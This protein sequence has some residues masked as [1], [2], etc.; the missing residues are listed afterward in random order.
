MLYCAGVDTHAF[1]NATLSNQPVTQF[2]LSSFPGKSA[3]KIQLNLF[4]ASVSK[5]E[6]S[7]ELF[8]GSNQSNRTVSLKSETEKYHVMI[9]FHT[10]VFPHEDFQSQ[11]TH[12]WVKPVA[13]PTS[14]LSGLGGAPTQRP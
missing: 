9:F 14:T 7:I 1:K 8:M 12:R 13:V 6:I 5:L 3:V 11:G 10:A 2:I 4:G